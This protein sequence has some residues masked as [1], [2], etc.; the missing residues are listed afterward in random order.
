MA[1]QGQDFKVKSGPIPHKYNLDTPPFTCLKLKQA[2]EAD[3]KKMRGDIKLERIILTYNGQVLADD[4]TF[5]PSRYSYEVS[6]TLA[7]AKKKDGGSSSAGEKKEGGGEK[8]ATI[9]RKPDLV[10]VRP[11]GSSDASSDGPV[12]TKIEQFDVQVVLTFSTAAAADDA[13]TTF[14]E[15][16]GLQDS[17]AAQIE[18]EREELKRLQETIERK[19]AFL[20]KAQANAKSE[21]D[22][23]TMEKLI[24]DL[25]GKDDDPDF[26]FFLQC[27]QHNYKKKMEVNAA[28]LGKLMNVVSNKFP[29]PTAG[30]EMQL[31]DKDKVLYDSST[32]ETLDETLTVESLGIKEKSTITLEW[33]SPEGEG[34]D[35]DG[36]GAEGEEQDDVVEVVED[37]AVEEEQVVVKKKGGEKF[38]PSKRK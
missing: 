7:G 6:M 1:A 32:V 37:D 14:A 24:K 35:E 33:L 25:D 23:A 12:V 9:T 15:T 22:K 38:K 27:R 8:K 20:E 4:Y 17:M 3:P 13:V 31:K 29:V 10:L 19:R 11:A 36:E 30:S 26:V 5:N 28:S 2:I 16:Y 18:K 34:S 21:R